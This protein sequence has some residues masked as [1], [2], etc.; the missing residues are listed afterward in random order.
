MDCSRKQIESS[1]DVPRHLQLE[2]G[3]V[4]TIVL[5]TSLAAWLPFNHLSCKFENIGDVTPPGLPV[6]TSLESRNDPSMPP[7]N[8]FGNV[9]RPY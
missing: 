3:G 4:L 8:I 5:P 7:S 2:E 9:M 6:G 1:S